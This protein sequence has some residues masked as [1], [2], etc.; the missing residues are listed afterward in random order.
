MGAL[1]GLNAGRMCGK[2]PGMKTVTIEELDRTTGLWL[3]EAVHHE[4]IVVTDRGQPIV[5][6]SPYPSPTSPPGRGGFRNRALLPEYER[7]MNL[8]VGGT[9]SSEIL[10]QD[11]E[12]RM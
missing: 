11:R 5:T 7:I 1:A 9:D 12:D 10:L 6:V 2:L 8:P 4:R 3:R